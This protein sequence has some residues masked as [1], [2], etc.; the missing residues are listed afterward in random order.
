MYVFIGTDFWGARHLLLVCIHGSGNKVV[1]AL[2]YYIV[3]EGH[4]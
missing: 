1:V 2:Y 4:K 3:K